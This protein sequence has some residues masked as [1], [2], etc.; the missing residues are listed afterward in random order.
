MNHRLN[1]AFIGVDVHKEQ[2]TAVIINCWTEVLGEFTFESKISVYPEFIKELKKKVPENL[3]LIFG[4]EDVGGNGRSLA[5]FLK[6]NGYLVKEVML[7]TLH[8]EKDQVKF[9]TMN[10]IIQNGI[11]ILKKSNFII[12]KRVN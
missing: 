3:N 9:I 1:C 7:K 4:L 11:L 2:H 10:L 12:K 5:V 8:H 6:E